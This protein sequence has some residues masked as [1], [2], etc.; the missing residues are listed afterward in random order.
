MSPNGKYTG[1]AS[2][3]RVNHKV[4]ENGGTVIPEGGTVEDYFD[5]N[6]DVRLQTASS[7]AFRIGFHVYNEYKIAKQFQLYHDFERACE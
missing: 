6:A 5:D 3:T 2:I 7:N 1:L 4:E